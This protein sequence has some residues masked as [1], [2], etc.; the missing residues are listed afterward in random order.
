[1]KDE[2]KA[3]CSIDKIFAEGIR[4]KARYVGDCTNSFDPDTGKCI[5]GIFRDVSDFAHKE[6]EIEE[7]VNEG[8]QQ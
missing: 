2:I 3:S 8:W 5:T 7:Q 1:M 4:Q 6:E